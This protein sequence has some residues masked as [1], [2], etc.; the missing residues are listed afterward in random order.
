MSWVR[1]LEW[2]LKEFLD[3]TARGITQTIIVAPL[4][5]KDVLDGRRPW[6]SH[7]VLARI[8]LPVS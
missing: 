1:T 3:C 7:P 8:V 6:H 5:V 2:L 4:T